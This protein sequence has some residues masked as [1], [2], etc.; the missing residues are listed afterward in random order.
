MNNN[1]VI[2]RTFPSKAATTA[3]DKTAA[4]LIKL[5][6]KTELKTAPS[7][8]K[9]TGTTK[10]DANSG[11]IVIALDALVPP[12]SKTSS[13]TLKV[14]SSNGVPVANI[15]VYLTEVDTGKTY[16]PETDAQGTI[17]I[18]NLPHGQYSIII[19][20]S[21]KFEQYKTN[22]PISFDDKNQFPNI[23][24]E[25]KSTTTKTSSPPTGL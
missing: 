22:S 21:A 16:N 13:A 14:I 12:S 7:Y 18:K 4:L 6:S 24:L 11:E 8:Q 25:S 20:V 5:N 17:K 1:E 10:V 9:Y 23:V 2:R 19:P 3:E 15:S